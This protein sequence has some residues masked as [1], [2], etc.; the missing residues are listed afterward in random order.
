MTD[1][2]IP[3]LTIE[4][5][6]GIRKLSLCN[7]GRVT[8]L[9]GKNSVG[10]STVL[11]AL[12]IFTSRGG[13]EQ[14][15]NILQS[16]EELILGIDEDGDEILH[17][18]FSTL[19]NESLFEE[20]GN[21]NPL[22]RIF[23]GNNKYKLSLELIN[24][25]A[26]HIQHIP[27]AS[28]EVKALKVTCGEESR[29]KVI[30]EMKKDKPFLWFDRRPRSTNTAPKNWPDPILYRF[31]GP[32]TQSND[33]ITNLWDT[34]AFTPEERFVIE[35]LRLI[36]GE[37]LEGITSIGGG[38][39]VFPRR[40][41]RELSDGS[42]RIIAKMKS[43]DHPIPLKRLGDGVQRLLGIALALA[44]CRNGILLIDEVENG[45][46]HSLQADLWRMLF[47]AAKKGNVQVFATTHSMDCIKGFAKAANESPEVGS[48]YR[49]ESDT[50]EVYPIQYTEE[51]LKIVEEQGMEVR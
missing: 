23:A 29:I 48:Y 13:D 10:K 8:L 50:E 30:G 31:L 7:L 27:E 41:I 17:P 45:I 32:G 37:E 2:F 46:H 21:K 15:F 36:A 38:F 1:L 49:L 43:L 5:F 4:G 20:S 39:V 16:R 12:Q 24:V 11:E 9:G 51:D 19:F 35:T 25:D 3:E 28:S 26:E 18:D 40:R 6:R 34:L 33:F 14:T 44:F 47:R 42:R 22:I